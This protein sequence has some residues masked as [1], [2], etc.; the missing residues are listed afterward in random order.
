LIKA[1]TL[2]DQMAGP[3]GNPAPHIETKDFDV[4]GQAE[5]LLHHPS[6]GLVARP[7]DGG[8]VSSLRF[9]PAGVELVNSLMRRPEP[10]H[11]LVRQKAITHDAPREGPA[12][13]HNHVWAKEPDM[14][15]LLRY[16]RYARHAFR[17]YVFSATRR[18]ED[19]D[20][21]RLNEN[22][23]LAG[24]PW[25]AVS[26]SARAGRLEFRRDA[27]QRANGDDV[28]LYA[29]KVLTSSTQGSAWQLACQ[30][31]LSQDSG[32][33]IPL[34]LGIE[35]VFNLLAPDAPD[36]YFLAQGIRRP[37]EFRGEIAAPRLILVDEWQRVQIALDADPTP[38]W[39]IVPIETISQSETGFERVY[40]GSAILAV[41]K[42]GPAAW[43][44][45]T[46]TLRVEITSLEDAPTAR[47]R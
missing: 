31:S 19:F 21:F 10:Y 6:Y 11:E 4:D 28:R 3:S 32:R 22:G 9:K 47:E 7:A 18:L 23:D 43:T 38:R 41:W 39:W 30:S 5:I 35:L 29:T 17:T 34:A 42:T 46:S 1:E 2:L 20:Y 13:I 40:Q 33:P 37:L 26:S 36:R 24:G 14:A 8:T 16:D 45:I 15:A 25:E 44:K 27:L 12:S